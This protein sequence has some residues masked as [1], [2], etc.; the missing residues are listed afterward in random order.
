M[1]QERRTSGHARALAAT[2]ASMIVAGGLLPFFAPRSFG[3]FAYQEIEPTRVILWQD[4][5]GMGLI[6]VGAVVLGVGCYRWWTARPDG[7]DR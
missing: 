7:R 2:G 1:V 5:V 4:V 6:G 3:W